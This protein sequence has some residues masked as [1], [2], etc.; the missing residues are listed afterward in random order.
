MIKPSLQLLFFFCL[1]WFFVGCESESPEYRFNIFV[2][3]TL[4]GERSKVE[5]CLKK[6]SI[7]YL[8]HDLNRTAIA[9]D[10]LERL[11]VDTKASRPIY[12][13]TE[14][15]VRNRLAK[16]FFTHSNGQVDYLLL[17]RDH[18]RWYIDLFPPKLLSP[19][20]ELPEF[21]MTSCPSG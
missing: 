20:A 4:Q 18:Q 1:G 16:V 15:L 12:Q 19:T 5:N 10:W 13:R 3:A 7:D 21:T 17:E 6:F 11:I 14:W 2:T 8:K 9:D